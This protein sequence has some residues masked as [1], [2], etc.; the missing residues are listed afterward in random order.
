MRFEC[1]AQSVCICIPRPVGLEGGTQPASGAKS[2]TFAPPW[3]SFCRN[4]SAFFAWR[5][6]GEGG[7]GERERQRERETE[8][9]EREREREREEWGSS[10][11]VGPL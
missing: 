1:A 6:R 7:G 10:V 4:F 3:P 5:E 8:R 11:N 9:D 2:G